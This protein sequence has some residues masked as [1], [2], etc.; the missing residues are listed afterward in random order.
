MSGTKFPYLASV[1]TLPISRLGHAR[2]VPFGTFRPQHTTRPEHPTESKS[3]QAS[4]SSA[5]GQT[6]LSA[7]HHRDV[8]GASTGGPEWPRG[9]CGEDFDVVEVN[10]GLENDPMKVA[11]R[12]ARSLAQVRISLH[13]ITAVLRHFLPRPQPPT[14]GGTS[15]LGCSRD[16]WP[17]KASS[18]S[19]L[20]MGE[21]RTRFRRKQRTTLR[22]P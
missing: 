20:S 15:H 14:G 17:G 2:A 19:G 16:G 21:H 8:Y 3:T 22:P 7:S 4:Q 13:S 1:A 12:G 9:G 5:L 6:V 10:A 11:L 18:T